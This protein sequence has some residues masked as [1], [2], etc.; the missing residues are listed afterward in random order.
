MTFYSKNDN[1]SFIHD[2][3]LKT[4]KAKA[5]YSVRQ[6]TVTKANQSGTTETRPH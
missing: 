4:D 5:W 3:P 2:A 6:Y 1:H